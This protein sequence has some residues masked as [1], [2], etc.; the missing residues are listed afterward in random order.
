MGSDTLIL[1]LHHLREREV[2]IVEGRVHVLPLL[3]QMRQ[4]VLQV[5]LVREPQARLAS[6]LIRLC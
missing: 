4:V 1:L 5:L 3:V 2:R 6:L